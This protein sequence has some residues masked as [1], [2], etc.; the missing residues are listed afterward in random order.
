MSMAT[1]TAVVAAG[2]RLTSWGSKSYTFDADGNMITR[3]AGGTTTLSK[4]LGAGAQPA[5]V[6]SRASYNT[7]R[8]PVRDVASECNAHG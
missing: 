3:T 4:R 8:A 5:L 6:L 7:P 1:D 2:N